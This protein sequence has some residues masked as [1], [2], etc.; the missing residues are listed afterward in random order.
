LAVLG[1]TRIDVV[2]AILVLYSEAGFRWDL[3]SAYQSQRLCYK[4]CHPFNS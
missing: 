4:P 3:R 1:V 2:V